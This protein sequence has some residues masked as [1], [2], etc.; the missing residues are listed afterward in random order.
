MEGQEDNHEGQDNSNEAFNHG[1]AMEDFVIGTGVVLL[2]AHNT[3]YY[4][5]GSKDNINEEYNKE[6]DPG[7]IGGKP[8]GDHGKQV[9]DNDGEGDDLSNFLEGVFAW[10]GVDL[11][12]FGGDEDLEAHLE[13]AEVHVEGAA[14]GF[15][16]IHGWEGWSDLNL[17]YFVGWWI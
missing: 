7:E 1:K 10:G 13:V 3:E 14:F 5:D 15:V 16:N 2:G 12:E 8:G 4:N 9:E 11:G 6:E 17:I